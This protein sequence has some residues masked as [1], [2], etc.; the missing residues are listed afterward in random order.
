MQLGRLAFAFVLPL[1]AAGLSLGCGERAGDP[2]VTLATSSAGGFSNGDAGGTGQG[3]GVPNA[4]G[5]PSGHDT[6][7]G[8]LGMCDQCRD[9]ADCGDQSDPCLRTGMD[10]GQCSRHC[11]ERDGCP[12]GYVCVAFGNMNDN[13]NDQLCVPTS[14][15]CP[16]PKEQA[17]SLGGLRE[18]I[19]NRVNAER[20]ARQRPP[21]ERDHCLDELAQQSAL[22]FAR[23]G[24]ELG[25][26]SRECET[27]RPNCECGW[28]SQAEVQISHY[29]LD[30]SGAVDRSLGVHRDTPSGRYTDAMLGVEAS[31]VGVGVWLAGDD[32][33]FALSFR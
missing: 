27:E 16:G 31:H 9:N 33:W 10:G 7:E 20:V 5:A 19:W 13:T 26:F 12:D 18:Y 23:T 28:A 1:A 8:P 30:W 6:E 29:D 14:G 32:A 17:P 25:K 11:D 15:V 24:E 22:E 4:S 2:V 3:S 21:F